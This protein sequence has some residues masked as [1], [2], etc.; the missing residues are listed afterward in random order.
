M[1]LMEKIGIQLEICVKQWNGNYPI[2][3]IYDIRMLQEF[4]KYWLNMI[5]TLHDD[6]S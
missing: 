5:V 4:E 1:K 2:W 6:L 3:I